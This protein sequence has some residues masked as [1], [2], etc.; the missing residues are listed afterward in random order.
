MRNPQQ[1]LCAR[2]AAIGSGTDEW[3]RAGLFAALEQQQAIV[4]ARLQVAERG[5]PPEQLLGLGQILRHALAQLVSLSQVEHRV[6]IALGH[7]G[8][9]FADRRG[10]VS[11]GPGIDPGLG[12]GLRRSRKNRPASSGD[13][14]DQDFAAHPKIPVLLRPALAFAGA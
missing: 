3:Q 13:G 9:P 6:G 5:G 7:R 1:I 2:I 8:L 12:I 10:E 11:P 14:G 4:V